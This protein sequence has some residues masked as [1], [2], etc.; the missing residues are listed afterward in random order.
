MEILLAYL[1]IGALAVYALYLCGIVE[2]AH[3]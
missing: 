3:R 1:I 2:R